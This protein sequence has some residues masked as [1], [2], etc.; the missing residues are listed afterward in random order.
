MSRA[1]VFGSSGFVGAAVSDV[2]KSRG[3]EVV[4][5]PRDSLTP[6]DGGFGV[7][8]WCIGLTADYRRRPL[9]TADAHVGI[10]TEVLRQ[11]AHEK[12]IYLSSARVYGGSEST[13][14]EAPLLLRPLF[15]SDVYN[16]TKLAGESVVLSSQPE[17]GVVVRPSN[18]I[19]PAEFTRHTFLGTIS[20]QAL[21]G[22]ISLE[23]SPISQKDY[24]WITDAAKV[25]ADIATVGTE[26]AYNLGRGMQIQHSQWVD[27]LASLTDCEVYVDPG[28]AVESFPQLDVSRIE[29]EFSFYPQD[30]LRHIAEILYG[31]K[32]LP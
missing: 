6:P 19:G 18:V 9:D 31:D 11:D 8:L 29:Q 32:G 13:S 1:T 16:A 12:F 17:R 23:S 10:L 5:Q 2:L 28:A 7:V 3:F 27:A 15:P 24:V 22:K 26:R 21:N 4:R 14:E 30:P 25:L 20:R